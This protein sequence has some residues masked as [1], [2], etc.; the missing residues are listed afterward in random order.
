MPFTFFLSHPFFIVFLLP[1]MLWKQLIKSKKGRKLGKGRNSVTTASSGL[2]TELL[3]KSLPCSG[4]KH[5]ASHFFVAKWL[6]HWYRS[7][8]LLAPCWYIMVISLLKVNCPWIKKKNCKVMDVNWLCR[9]NCL[10]FFP[11]VHVDCDWCNDS[12]PFFCC[13]ISLKRNT[14][15]GTV[16]TK[17]STLIF[18]PPQY[19]GLCRSNW[20]YQLLKCFTVAQPSNMPAAT[21][22]QS[23][24]VRWGTFPVPLTHQR[25]LVW[26]MEGNKGLALSSRWWQ[27]S[28]RLP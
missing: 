19:S 8:V 13:T 3:I 1:L 27:R 20:P 4:T 25:Y 6:S 14:S 9:K 28:G 12:L 17:A 26:Q 24:G 10:F 5:S 15:A 2:N 11:P 18:T 23:S 7:T 22:L 21:F 16:F